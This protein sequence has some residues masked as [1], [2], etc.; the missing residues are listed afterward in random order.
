MEWW[1]IE[2]LNGRGS[3]ARWKD[4]CNLVLG[5]WLALSPWVLAYATEATAAWNAHVVGVI[6]AV[7]SFAALVAFQ[8][9]EEWVSTAL[10]A[11]LIVSPYLLGFSGMTAALWNQIIVG[12]L[13]GG[14]AIWSAL[15]APSEGAHAKG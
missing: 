6:I 7:A 8:K 9:W 3:A 10:A 13:V 1:S 4:A 14:L 2:V 5:V 15:E 11:W 12:L